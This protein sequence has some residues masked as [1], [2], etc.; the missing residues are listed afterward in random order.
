MRQVEEGR[1][2]IKR[3][4]RLARDFVGAEHHL[5]TV[6]GI[7]GEL[8]DVGLASGVVDDGVVGSV[9]GLCSLEALD[10]GAGVVEGGIVDRV[11]GL[12]DDDVD[13]VVFA[14]MGQVRVRF[15]ERESR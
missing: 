12:A 2:G 6:E 9:L 13:G 15:E 3:I 7:L 10:E 4:C 8:L 14:Y 11:E 5:G 1:R